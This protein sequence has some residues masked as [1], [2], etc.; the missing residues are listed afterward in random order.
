MSEKKAETAEGYSGSAH[1]GNGPFKRPAGAS[2]E[3]VVSE[4]GH[5]E[6]TIELGGDGVTPLAE[7]EKKKAEEA[8]LHAAHDEKMRQKAIDESGPVLKTTGH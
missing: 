7:W 1:E 8:K 6:P 4:V 5:T 2:K 3:A